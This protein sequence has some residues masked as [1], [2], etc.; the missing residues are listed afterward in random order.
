MNFLATNGHPGR[1]TDAHSS[2]GRGTFSDRRFGVLRT[3]GEDRCVVGP[4]WAWRRESR[5]ACQV[6]P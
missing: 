2:A 3:Y 1:K 5:L 4:N 6:Y